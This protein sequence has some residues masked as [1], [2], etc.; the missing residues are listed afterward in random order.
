MKTRRP[1]TPEEKVHASKVM[2][3]MWDEIRAMRPHLGV[4]VDDI[5]R[6]HGELRGA[7]LIQKVTEG[8]EAAIRDAKELLAGQMP[9]FKQHEMVRKT[10]AGK[11]VAQ[12]KYC[13]G[14][15]T[16]ED[17]VRR[18]VNNVPGL[19]DVKIMLWA[20]EKIGSVEAATKAFERATSSLR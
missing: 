9:L 14:G 7:G 6:R 13:R 3:K 16:P 10:R 1:R 19:N 4:S 11:K 12:D 2:K 17:V 20:I 8:D 18:V 5:A 15:E